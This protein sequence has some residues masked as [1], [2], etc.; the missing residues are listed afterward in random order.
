MRQLLRKRSARTEDDT[1]PE[2]PATRRD[3]LA[4]QMALV[5]IACLGLVFVVSRDTGFLMP[6][7]LASP[8]ATIGECRSCHTNS[9]TGK[10]SWLRGF[11][12]G[13]RLADSK[14][15]LTCHQM[16]DTAFNAHGAA[17]EVLTRST[18]RLSKLGA[19]T[20]ASRSAH[21]QAVAFPTDAVTAHGLRCATCHQEHQGAAFDLK[22]ISD[23]RC[24]SCHVVKF[25]GFENRHPEFE[26]YPFERRTRII[27]D[28]AGHFGK[29]FPEIAKKDPAK[30]I[31]TT[32]SSCHDG[33][34]D[35]RIMGVAPFEQTCASC[36]LDQIRGKERLSGPKGIA[37][38]AVPGLDLQ[39][40]KRRKAD[41]GEWPEASEA[42]LTPFMKVIIGRQ[43]QG[44]SL[45]E[46]VDELDLQDLRKATDDQIIA[47][48]NLAWEIKKLFHALLKARASDALTGL[49][50]RT[51]PAIDTSDREKPAAPVITELTA[52]IPL[53]VLSI[54]Q[55]QWLPNLAAEIASRPD[56]SGQRKGGWT[57]AMVAPRVPDEG[58][59]AGKAG[60]RT[61]VKEKAKTGTAN[62]AFPAKPSAAQSL[63]ASAPTNASSS[64]KASKES[65]S[66]AEVPAA[67]AVD[68]TDD[69]LVLT[70]A[71]LRASKAA[72]RNAKKAPAA[73]QGAGKADTAAVTPNRARPRAA[74]AASDPIANAAEPRSPAATST[75]IES[76]TNPEDWA[77]DGGWYRQDHAIYYRP[78]GHADKFIS[79]WL[80][81]VG[82]QTRKASNSPAAATFDALT[83]KDAKGSCTKCHSIDFNA[84][85]RAVN[86]SA[87]AAE[88]RKGRFTKFSHRPHMSIVG[89]SGCTTCHSLVQGSSY[90]ESY[91]QGD[92]QRHIS[93]FSPMKLDG[94][95]TCHSRGKARQDCLT[96]HTYHVNGAI[97][98]VVDT[99]VPRQ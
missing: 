39:T 65:P 15:C 42:A 59:T 50:N 29:H 2:I 33:G 64:T 86:F 44:R 53:D 10:V 67:K 25:D 73:I 17:I 12:A 88:P 54:A 46:I 82:P 55:Q 52:S 20:R 57:T 13:D 80:R 58:D 1:P 72:G 28:H 14:A 26:G 69:L 99:P 36:H 91:E 94:C 31:P 30:R 76:G 34:K 56:V 21:A 49:D 68:Q 32:C 96:C 87:S 7:P 74:N 19:E 92:P 11:F 93:N 8:H 18:Q 41:V 45:I 43:Q 23:A 9:G 89:Q 35:K 71:E 98:P 4:I 60:K 97:T 62:D 78:T 3:R 63:G 81:L 5:T 51:G 16:P 47:V 84:E 48:T 40:L 83:G 27:Y 95:R 61:P 24:G 38:L 70:E 77:E 66:P 85:G 79:A 90:L 6:G 22:K 75:A 37:F